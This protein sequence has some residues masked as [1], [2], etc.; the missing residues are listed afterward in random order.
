MAKLPQFI[1]LA[2][3]EILPLHFTVGEMRIPM[4]LGKRSIVEVYQLAWNWGLLRDDHAMVR[5]LT[6][7]KLT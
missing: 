7:L 2:A 6:E 5:V 3:P 4:V 1:E